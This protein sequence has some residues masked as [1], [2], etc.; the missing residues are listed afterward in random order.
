MP[1][2]KDVR[3][4]EMMMRDWFAA[5]AVEGILSS[6]TLLSPVAVASQAYEIADAMLEERAK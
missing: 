3:I 5:Q 6:D 2:D 4:S 1:T